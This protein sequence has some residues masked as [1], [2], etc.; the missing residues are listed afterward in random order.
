M[1]GLLLGLVLSLN[2]LGSQPEAVPNHEEIIENYY[3]LSCYVD[4]I[5]YDN[6][7][8]TVVDFGTENEWE[9][10]GVEDW[11]EGDIC[12]MIM[13]DNGTQTIYDDEIVKVKYCG[14]IY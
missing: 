13:Y 11:M 12:S 9:F 14:Y 1:L 8:V 7:I 3:P 2:V 5:D 4:Y 10:E 6:N